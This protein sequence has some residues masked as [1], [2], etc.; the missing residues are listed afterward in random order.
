M[1]NK[2]RETL[3]S[4]K[5]LLAGEQLSSVIFVQDYL[6]VDFD[7]N[8]FTAFVFPN[9]TI[10]DTVFDFQKK[11]YRDALCSLIA[12]IVADIVLA[13]GAELTIV[14]SNGNKL[15]FLIAPEATKYEKLIFTSQN[16]S[17]YIWD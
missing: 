3:I 10:N 4:L 11:G 14:F 1:E 12:A 17:D 7:G 6:Q 15:V 16:R 5:E 9:V 2:D 13:E 8:V